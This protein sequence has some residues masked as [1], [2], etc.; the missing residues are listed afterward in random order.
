MATVGWLS[1]FLHVICR[2]A[3]AA[4]GGKM[5]SKPK[6]QQKKKKAKSQGFG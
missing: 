4:A 6:Q 1:F 3:R 2:E 5:G